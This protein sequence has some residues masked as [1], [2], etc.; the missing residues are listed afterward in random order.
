LSTLRLVVDGIFG[1][2]TRARVLQFQKQA[3]LGADGIFGPM[4]GKALLGHALS[5]VCTKH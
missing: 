4:T 1:P 2:K 3:Q 5:K